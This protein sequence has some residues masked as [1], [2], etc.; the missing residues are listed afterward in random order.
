[1]PLPYR[2]ADRLVMVW[3][4]DTRLA[5]GRMPVAPADFRDWREQAHSFSAMASSGDV[6]FN[7]TGAGDPEMIIGYAFAPEMFPLLG[8]TPALGRCFSAD[9]GDHVVVLSHG[10]WKR[11]FGGDPGIVGASIT[12]DHESYHVIGVMGPEFQHPMRSQMWVPLVLSPAQQASRELA[13]LR[14]VARL[15]PGISIEQAGAEMSA[16]AGRLARAYADTNHDRDVELE[17]MRHTI[18]GGVRAPLLLL[19]GAVGFVLLLACSNVAGLLL[20]PAAARQRGIGIR[21]ALGAGPGRIGRQML[22]ESL[23]LSLLAGAAGL[24]LALWGV[25][26]LVALFPQHVGNLR[27]PRIGHIPIDGTV[28]AF[29]VG[30]SMLSGLGFG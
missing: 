5:D 4:K 19:L 16:I 6:V 17:S 14:I 15:A 24:V 18:T 20:A 8:V 7:L 30:V 29:T 25:S 3:S 26:V 13:R 23:V 1:R 28:L 22:T 9:D 2:D 10:L 12:L 21:V 27:I 11:R